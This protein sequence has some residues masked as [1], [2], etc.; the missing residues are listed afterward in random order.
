MRRLVL[1]SATAL[2]CL[3][4]SAAPA[5]AYGDPNSLV[6]YW[7][8]TY[9]GRP[10]DSGITYWVNHLAQGDSPDSVLAGLLASDE[11]YKRAGGTPQGFITLLHRD[12]IKRDPSP[13]EMDFWVR[14]MYTEDRQ[15]VADDILTQNPGVW[16]GAGPPVAPTVT[17]GVIVTPGIQYNHY[18]DWDRD[19]RG[20]WDRHYDIHDYRRPDNHF[21]PPEHKDDHHH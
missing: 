13:A 17:P 6:D 7:Y 10:A 19:R 21:R 3:A 12:I 1:I 2:F 16:V 14:R 15:G 5:Q 11:Y 9:L 8:R 18:R 20:D 4:P